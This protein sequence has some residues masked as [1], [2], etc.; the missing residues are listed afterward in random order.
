MV[1]NVPIEGGFWGLIAEDGTKYDPIELPVEYQIDGLKVDF[2]VKELEDVGGIHQWGKIVEIIKI[3][4][5]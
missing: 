1:I 2:Q 4:K 5:Q 3:E